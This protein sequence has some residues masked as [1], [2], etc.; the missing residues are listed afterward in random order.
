MRRYLLLL[1]IA[2]ISAGIVGAQQPADA[3]QQ[4]SVTFRTDINFVEVHAIVTNEEGEFVKD[5]TADDF[6]INEDGQ[7]QAPAVFS[8]GD[9]PIERPFTPRNA[10]AP[11][12]PDV[13]ATT[14]TFDG[15]IYILLLDDLHTLVTRTQDVRRVARGFIEEYLG[16]NDLAAVLFTSGRRESGQELTGSRRLLTE[17]ID[18]FQ[19]RKLPS[20]GAEKLGIRL[21]ATD[22]GVAGVL[23]SE[24]DLTEL[25][26]DHGIA[27][28]TP[29][30]LADDRYGGA[31]TINGTRVPPS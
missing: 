3:G 16:A 30:H 10:D 11:I 9:V 2:L 23:E 25:I 13:R 21:L 22:D 28:V 17:A 19:G 20:A 18:R 29:L 5:L 1:P 15:R 26:D 6:E 12:E 4:P 8:L 31:A 7:P 27:I 24:E 14:R